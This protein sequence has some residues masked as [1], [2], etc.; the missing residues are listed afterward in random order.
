VTHPFKVKGCNIPVGGGYFRAAGG[1][2]RSIEAL[3]RFEGPVHPLQLSI[4]FNI[5]VRFCL[6]GELD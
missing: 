1:D 6:S 4:A 5:P 2:R 3:K